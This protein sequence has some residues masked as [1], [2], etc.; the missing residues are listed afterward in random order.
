M[1]HV[2]GALL[3]MTEHMVCY[4]THGNIIYLKE[5]IMLSRKTKLGIYNKNAFNSLKKK[6][7][8]FVRIYGF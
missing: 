3:D 2:N 1:K 5:T 8:Y 7:K 6:G 4:F